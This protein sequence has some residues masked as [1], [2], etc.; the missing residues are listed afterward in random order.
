[1]VLKKQIERSLYD[2]MIGLLQSAFYCPLRAYGVVI[3]EILMFGQLP[4]P[5]KDT[6]GIIK[7]AQNKRLEH[8]R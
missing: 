6:Q 2:T 3:W 1:M 7:A 8:L 4:L 5:N